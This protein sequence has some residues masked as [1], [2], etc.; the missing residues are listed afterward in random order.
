MIFYFSGTGNSQWVAK[1]L[2]SQLGD[3]LIPMADEEA[4]N[5]VYACAKGE[6]VGFVFPVYAWS[7][8]K[9]VFDFLA[10]VQLDKPNYLYFVCT[11]GDDTGKTADMFIDAVKRRGWTCHAG[12]SVTMPNTYVSLPGFD[13]DDCDTERMKVQ[14]AVARVEYIAGEV[15]QNVRMHKYSCHEGA[16]P[17]IKTYVLGPLF[18][19]FL[20][21][22]KPFRALD[23][24]TACK[25]CEKKCP[26]HN[27]KVEGKPQWGSN[28]T[29]CLACYH[30]CPIKAIQY[31]NGTKGKGQYKG[32]HLI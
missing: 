14:N 8:P 20:M 28:C 7:P 24:C 15:K 32:E 5:E 22:P 2:A 30:V 1:Q 23:N 11:C 9:V 16:V 4:L 12:Y 13:V 3:T 25:R 26:V 17:F 19:R 31:G 21:S 10:R 6:R 27:I 18:N 29:M